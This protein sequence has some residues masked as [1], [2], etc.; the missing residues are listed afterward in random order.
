M[1]EIWKRKKK[2]KRH[3]RRNVPKVVSASNK[4]AAWKKNVR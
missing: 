3:L 2:K 4:I 1:S